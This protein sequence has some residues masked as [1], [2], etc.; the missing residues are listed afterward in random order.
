MQDLYLCCMAQIY[1]EDRGM[2]YAIAY[3]DKVAQVIL[4]DHG[5]G[6]QVAGS[7]SLLGAAGESGDGSGSSAE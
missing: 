3:G 2:N 4:E 7:R 6:D 1:P 5:G